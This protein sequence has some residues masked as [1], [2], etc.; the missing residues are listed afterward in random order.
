MEHA[1]RDDAAATYAEQGFYIV[2][3]EVV[4]RDAIVRAL[5]H[6]AAVNAGLYSTGVSPWRRWNVGSAEQVQKID[7][8]HL[9]DD[10]ILELVTHPAIGQWVARVT[11]ARWVQLWATQLITKPPGGGAQGHIGWHDDDQNWAFLDG[12]ALTVWL[13]LCPVA[14]RAGPVRFLPGSHHWP[15]DEVDRGDAYDQDLDEQR[16]RIVAAVDPARVVPEVEAV[17][18]L[19]G[20]SIHGRYTMHCSGA[21][22]SR[23]P[24]LGIAINVRTE[25]SAPA[26][27]VEDHGYCSHLDDPRICPV[28]FDA[29]STGSPPS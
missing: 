25:R 17:L 28:L 22:H 1:H 9:S 11:G 15:R 14:S 2:P 7:Q 12:E 29:D 16:A 4:P 26:P 13:A 19:G 20:L 10:A 23:H 8:A 18:P 6:C 27:G 3:E 21:N 5:P 24:R